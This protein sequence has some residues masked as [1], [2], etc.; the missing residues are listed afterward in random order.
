[1]H[2]C[3]LNSNRH[4]GDEFGY[5]KATALDMETYMCIYAPYLFLY[6]NMHT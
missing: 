5:W 2:A 1:M 3:I 6:Q 4:A